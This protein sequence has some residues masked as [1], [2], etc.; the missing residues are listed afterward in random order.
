[1]DKSLFF[2]GLSI[3]IMQVLAVF[4]YLLI[5]LDWTWL[6]SKILVAVVGGLVFLTFNI[7]AVIFLIVGAL[8]K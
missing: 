6:N 7:A 1:M 2:R 4:A 5:N 8:R 3:I